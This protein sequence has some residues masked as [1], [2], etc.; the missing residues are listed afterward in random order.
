MLRARRVMGVMGGW[1]RGA[2]STEEKLM[3]R[4]TEYCNVRFECG[5]VKVG[6]VREDSDV[7]EG[8]CAWG[9]RRR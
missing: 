6:R 8:C 1:I 4:A 3:G 9:C 2:P 7:S 5:W